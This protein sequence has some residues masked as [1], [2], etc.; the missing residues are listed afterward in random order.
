MKKKTTKGKTP[1]VPMPEKQ[2]EIE[3]LAD[4]GELNIPPE[5]PA[6]KEKP[7]ETSPYDFPPP[8]EGYFPQ[9]F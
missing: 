9:I 3:P 8:G 1:E 4:P 6:P 2:P 7:S 5:Y